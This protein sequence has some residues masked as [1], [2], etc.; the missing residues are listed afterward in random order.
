[1]IAMGLQQQ[2]DL[3]C[4]Q[5]ETDWAILQVDFKNAF[6]CQKREEMLQA[7][8]RRC[9]EAFPWLESCYTRHSSTFCGKTEIASQR[10]MQQGDP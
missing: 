3:K 9:P 5:G 4:D 7:V 2:V 8:L 6:N 10:G 1:M